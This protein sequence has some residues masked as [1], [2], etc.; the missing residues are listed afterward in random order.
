MK[1]GKKAKETHAETQTSSVGFDQER[2]H[3]ES[4]SVLLIAAMSCPL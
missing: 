3:L 2:L 4:P 1:R